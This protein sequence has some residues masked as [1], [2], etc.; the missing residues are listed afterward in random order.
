MYH[1]IS[2]GFYCLSFWEL[3]YFGKHMQHTRF[4]RI[5]LGYGSFLGF[6]RQKCA[7][8]KLGGRVADWNLSGIRGLPY[9]N[10]KYTKP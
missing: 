3:L 1:F 7:S 6:T 8:R 9:L 10:G 2:V 4:F 5:K